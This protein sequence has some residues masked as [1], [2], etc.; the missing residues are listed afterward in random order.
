[1][2]VWLVALLVA[3]SEAPTWGWGSA[4]VIGL[5][6]V[7]VALAVAWVVLETRSTHPLID[8]RMMRLPAVWTAN[9]VA[10]LFGVGMYAV[11]AFLPEFLQT[12][13]SAGYGFGVSITHSGLILLPLSVMMFVFG[14]A[15]GR[16]TLRF[17]GRTVLILGSTVSVIPF[18]MLVVAHTQQW[19]IVLA[20][21][22]LGSGFGLAFAAVMSSIVTASAHH[23]GLPRESGYTHGFEL[24]TAAAVAAALAALLVPSRLRHLS[25][26][27]L[28]AALPHAELAQVAS[29]TLIGDEPE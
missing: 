11:F 10:L 2:S 26:A 12:A 3:I 13:P 23:G 20:M 8:M 22:L 5:G 19:E 15:S 9:L 27:E 14:T 24:L 25:R 18:L 29:G 1:M 28:H 7:A 21:A 6:L 4:R 16:L 17:G